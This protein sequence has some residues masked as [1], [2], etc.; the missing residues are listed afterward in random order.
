MQGS[1]DYRLPETAG[2]EAGTKPPRDDPADGGS[3][4]PPATTALRARRRSIVT[5]F[6]IDGTSC[7]PLSK[8]RENGLQRPPRRPRNDNFGSGFPRIAAGEDP[9]GVARKAPTV[10]WTVADP[11][12]RAMLEATSHAFGRL[13]GTG[14]GNMAPSSNRTRTYGKHRNAGS[15]PAGAATP[16]G[17]Y[18]HR[19]RTSFERTGQALSVR[20]CGH[21]AAGRVPRI[22]ARTAG[23]T[24]RGGA[25][26]PLRFI[27]I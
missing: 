12:R 6:L 8:L 24:A 2:F 23:K 14:P 9:A 25:V 3:R 4:P 16:A 13:C 27:K 5:S 21:S 26:P 11:S 17:F 7:E 22:G 19:R 10:R 1:W 15:S 20:G 18:F